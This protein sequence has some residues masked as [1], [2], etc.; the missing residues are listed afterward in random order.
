MTVDA[1]FTDFPILTTDRLQLRQLQPSNAEALF[2]I[3]SDPEVT[4]HYGQEPHQ[5]RDETLWWIQG[6]RDS[7]GRREDLPGV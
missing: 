2:A 7:Y 4:K 5:S 3:K 1:V 6:L